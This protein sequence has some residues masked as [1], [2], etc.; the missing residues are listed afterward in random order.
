MGQIEALQAL[1]VKVEAG[2]DSI[3]VIEELAIGA[4][5]NDCY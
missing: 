4:F 2:E 5:G 1:L 3:V